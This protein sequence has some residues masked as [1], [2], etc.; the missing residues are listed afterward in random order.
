MSSW[1]EDLALALA[2]QGGRHGNEADI[3]VSVSLVGGY[4]DAF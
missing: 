4:R 2:T 3:T 1:A